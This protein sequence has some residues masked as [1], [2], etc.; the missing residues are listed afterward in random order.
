MLISIVIRTLN[1]AEH[2]GNLLSMIDKQTWPENQVETVIVDSGSSDGTL[3]IARNHGARITTITK[4]EFSFGKSLNLGCEF[5]GGDIIVMISGHCV[6]VSDDWLF[7]L[8]K[9]LI[10]GKVSYTYGRQIGDDTSNFSERRIFAKY[11][12]SQSAVPQAG[13]FCNNANAAILR[14]AWSAHLFDEGITGLEDMELAKRLIGSGHR[15]GYVAEAPV[16]HYHKEK[17]GQIRHRFEREAIA[18][19]TIMPEIHLRP[20]DVLRFIVA[21]TIGDWWTAWRNG[22]SSTSALDMFRYRYNQYFGSYSGNHEHR[23]LSQEAKERFFFPTP[24]KENHDDEWLK[25]MRRPSTNEGQQPE[26]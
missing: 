2:L 13:F 15:V 20:L 11:F 22:N 21:S 14:S 19:R 18:L 23:I 5:S 26:S 10:E 17:W 3:E 7:Q 8:C 6:P 9:P 12:P 16:F 1:E 4:S 24:A 25:A